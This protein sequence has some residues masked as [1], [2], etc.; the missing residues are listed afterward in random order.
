MAIKSIKNCSVSRK[1]F[2]KSK[3]IN[4]N[5]VKKH[6][7][8]GFLAEKANRHYQYEYGHHCPKHY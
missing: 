7:K 1:I 4:R 2:K 8:R 5:P 3:N 6:K